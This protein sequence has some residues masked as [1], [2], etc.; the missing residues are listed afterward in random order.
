MKQSVKILLNNFKEMKVQWSLKFAESAV[1]T[2]KKLVIFHCEIFGKR[3][4]KGN[5]NDLFTENIV[6][7]CFLANIEVWIAAKHA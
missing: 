2:E 4:R 7:T 5:S 1:P 3:L 6:D